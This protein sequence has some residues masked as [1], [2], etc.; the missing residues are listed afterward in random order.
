MGA[1]M[2]K[3]KKTINSVKKPP[4]LNLWNGS[5]ECIT[6]VPEW[7]EAFVIDIQANIYSSGGIRDLR[8]WLVRAEKWIKNKE[9]YE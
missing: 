9:R 3:K 1:G 5:A 7:N 4:T 6:E 2:S 8:R